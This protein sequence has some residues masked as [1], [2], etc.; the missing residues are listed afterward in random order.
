MASLKIEILANLFDITNQNITSVREEPGLQQRGLGEDTVGVALFR[1]LDQPAVLLVDSVG[2]EGDT[3]GG[4]VERDAGVDLTARLL[5]LLVVDLDGRVRSELQLQTGLL[6]ADGFAGEG[7]GDEVAVAVSG[8]GR[9]ATAA[10][11]VGDDLHGGLGRGRSSGRGCGS[12]CRR[13]SRSR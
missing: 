3:V 9:A 5:T 6:V 10:A 2:A 8:V 4:L 12:S 7:H 11:E 1:E 13:S